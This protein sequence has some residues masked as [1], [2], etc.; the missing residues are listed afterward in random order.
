[1]EE[2]GKVQRERGG[3][4]KK[5]LTNTLSSLT[6]IPVVEKESLNVLE[7]QIICARASEVINNGDCIFIDSGT[8]PAYLI[9]YLAGKE[10]KIV[11]N[12]IFLLYKLAKEY[13]GEVYVLGGQF[14]LKYGMNLGPITMDEIS[15][16]RFDHAFLGASGIEIDSDEI[17]SA[18]FSIGAIK[19]AVMKRSNHKYLIVDDSKYSIKGI[20]TW[21][22]MVDFD[23]LFV[24]NFPDKKKKPKNMIICN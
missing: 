2:Q 24:N 22:N 15:K 21:A 5:D 7:K 16:F 17:F 1:L 8:T 20:C 13:Q 3:A 23:A 19:I 9:P 6:E 12:S 14:N 18:D 11:T 4:I 10:I